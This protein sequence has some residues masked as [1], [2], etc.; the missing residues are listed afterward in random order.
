MKFSSGGFM[1]L[2]V[3]FRKSVYV[4][5]AT[6]KKKNDIVEFLKPVVKFEKKKINIVPCLEEM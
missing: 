3:G 2:E 4:L 6:H 5:L 1:R